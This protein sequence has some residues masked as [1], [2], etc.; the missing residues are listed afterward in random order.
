[1]TTHP[2]AMNAGL[3]DRERRVRGADDVSDLRSGLMSEQPVAMRV[4]N[5]DQRGTYRHKLE[6]PDEASRNST[7]AC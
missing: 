2:T 6:K 7:V 4:D 3:T 5:L 1:M